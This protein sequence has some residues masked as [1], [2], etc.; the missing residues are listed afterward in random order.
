MRG[1]LMEIISVSSAVVD[2]L[3]TQIVTGKFKANQKI[4]ENDLATSL[5][6][7]R[8]PIREAFRTLENDHLIVSIPRKGTYVTS[9]S[10]KDFLGL[11]QVRE[12]IETY[13]IDFLKAQNIRELPEVNVA[14]EA[15]THL[16]FPSIESPELMIQYTGTITDFHRKLIEAVGNDR[17]LHIYR[18]ISLNLTRYQIIYFFFVQDSA[19]HSLQ[20]HEE[21]FHLIK[22]GKYDHAK[23]CLLNHLSYIEKVIKDKIRDA[24]LNANETESM[25]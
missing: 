20:H 22:Q 2:Y 1:I 25:K 5:G 15:G 23:V 6:I 4:N 8:P 9:L 18:A 3:R 7:S 19:S 14:L 12:M 21:I 16:S 10:I 24:T 17:I 13:S 11:C